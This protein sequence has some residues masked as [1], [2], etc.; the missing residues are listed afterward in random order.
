MLH[1]W[2]CS[3]FL[4]RLSSGETRTTRT[5]AFW[6]YP[7][8]LMITH[9]LSHIG[10][11]VKRR[12]SQSHKFKKI[13]KM[14]NFWIVKQALHATHHLKLLNEM[15]K[16]KMDPMSIVEDTEQIRFSPQTDRRTDETE[17]VI[18]VY[19]PFNFVEAG[20]IITNLQLKF[21]SH[22]MVHLLRAMIHCVMTTNYT[23]DQ[24]AA[25]S[26]CILYY[27]SPLYDSIVSK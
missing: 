1:W 9:T 17:R 8:C 26:Q 12:Q 21:C 4:S 6:G 18:P 14:S 13:A 10:S 2:Y 22:W 3:W 20:G 19:H 24:L 5:P 15:C 25:W 23:C 7:R 11:K 16:Y 27:A